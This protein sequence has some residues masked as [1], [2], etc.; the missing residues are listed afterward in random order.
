MYRYRETID[1]GRD[2]AELARLT[3]EI[4]SAEMH[5]TQPELSFI[6]ESPFGNIQEE[7]RVLGLAN[8]LK[9]FIL[10]GLEPRQLIRTTAHECRHVKHFFRSSLSRESRE[11]DAEI[12]GWEFT[13]NLRG[14]NY[15]ELLCELFLRKY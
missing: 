9:I 11:R 5:M 10:C 15:R 1:A 2:E 8:S 12:Y 6:I 13:Q 4:A 14:T 3:C 7:F